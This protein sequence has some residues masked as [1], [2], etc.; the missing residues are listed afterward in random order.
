M[1]ITYKTFKISRS[2]PGLVLLNRPSSMFSS[3][4]IVLILHTMF[5]INSKHFKLYSVIDFFIR[6]NCK[7]LLTVKHT[8]ISKFSFFS[9]SENSSFSSIRSLSCIEL[10]ISIYWEK[11]DALHCI[12]IT[13]VSSRFYVQARFNNFQAINSHFV[14][15]ISSRVYNTFCSNA[16]ALTMNVEYSAK[17]SWKS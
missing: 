4:L 17:N 9:E 5:L 12:C 15:D 2:H 6:K 1:I 13:R 8:L 11:K 3:I 14:S 10:T 16:K 7:S